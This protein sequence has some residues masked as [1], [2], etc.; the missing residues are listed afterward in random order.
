MEDEEIR[1]LEGG[2]E[3]D[4]FNEIQKFNTKVNHKLK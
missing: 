4:A 1:I 3:A 2:S